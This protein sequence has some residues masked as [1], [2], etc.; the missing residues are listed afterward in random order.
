MSNERTTASAVGVYIGPI[1]G[2]EMEILFKEVPMPFFLH[3][4]SY[5]PEALATAHCQSARSF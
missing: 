2:S 1:L 5:T 3:Q 4:V